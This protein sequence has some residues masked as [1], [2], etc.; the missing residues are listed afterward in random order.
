V[1]LALV[2]F[3][4]L[5]VLVFLSV[6]WFRQNGERIGGSVTARWQGVANSPRFDSLRTRHPQL[7]S[8]VAARFARGE[9]LGLHLSLGFLVSLATLWLFG[10]V[11][12]DIVHHDPL[13]AVDLQLAT[14]MRAH[15]S[16]LGDRI[17]VAVSALGSPVAM[18]VLAVIVAAVLVR[19]RQWIVLA[20][21][22]AAYA[23]DG[24]LN[25]ALKR[26]VHRPRP[27][28][29][30]HFL[31]GTS[32]SFPSE[33]AMGSLIEYGMLA[34]LLIGFWPW[35]RRHEVAVAIGTFL[36]VFMIGLSRLYLGVHFL[37]DVIGGYAAGLVW[38]VMCATGV[39]I[40]LRQ[41][42]FGR[43]K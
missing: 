39:E 8:F 12:E 25:W 4:T 40:A 18:A 2:L 23:G 24:M 19:R 14:W 21:W 34:Y 20:G 38:L 35:A 37:S 9:Y 33:H 31:H 1:S 27:P 30:E 5:G 22:V 15:A 7:W 36:L 43:G 10:G 13:T 6:H 3:A 32:F 42:E 11:T 26:V 41:R 16:P 29:A 17:G 28:G